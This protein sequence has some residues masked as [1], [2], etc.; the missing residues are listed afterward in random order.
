MSK[1]ILSSAEEVLAYSRKSRADNPSESVEEVLAKHERIIQETCQREFGF[2]LPEG[3]IYREI[4]SGGESID[5]RI[6]IK[7]VLA[8]CED[9]KIKAIIVVEPQRL[10][11]GDLIDCGRL[12]DTLRYSNTMVVTPTMTYDLN[13]K[14]ERRF[15]QDEL[16][17][18]RDYLEYVKE[19]LSRGKLESLKRGCYLQGQAPFGYD[20]IKIGKDNT[21]T[22][23]DDADTVRMIFNMFIDG[24]TTYEIEK[25]M[26]RLGIKTPNG[27]TQWNRSS[28]DKMIRNQHYIGKVTYEQ[29]KTTVMVINGEKVTKRQK[30]KD[31][32]VFEGKHPAIIDDDVFAKAQ[33]KMNTRPPVKNDVI[34][35]NALAGMLYC[36]RCGH[37]MSYKDKSGDRA[38]LCC[39][40]VGCSKSIKYGI[41][42]DTITK[43]LEQ[44]ELPNLVVKWKNGE[45][46]SVEIQKKVLAN[47]EKELSEL[48]SQE[49]RQFELL[50]TNRYTEEVFE[51]RHNALREK[52]GECI[53]RIEERK[54]TMPKAV[55]YE[56]RIAT[57]NEAIQSLKDNSVPETKK[58]AL[59]KTIIER[60]D[61]TSIPSDKRREYEFSLNVQLK[62]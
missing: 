44:S 52:I 53:S 56:E 4:V 8:K 23:N 32:L 22:P 14:M 5:D 7:K 10:S 43:T 54:R 18:G 34:L 36:G 19:I 51:K 55:N 20:R 42:M 27:N 24:A 6:E 47:L 39:K 62:L 16:M 50:E 29:Y 41:M 33:A 26:Q 40:T 12:I 15:F 21:L 13:N 2:N 30:N 57:L 59:L 49:D 45:G 35:R 31:Y 17:R 58:N 37:I 46:N 25:E 60:I 9:S 11:R 1:A 61:C 48:L 3:N 38:Y 28:I